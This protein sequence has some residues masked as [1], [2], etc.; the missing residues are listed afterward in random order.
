[1]KYIMLGTIS[2]QWASK[3]AERTARAKAKLQQLGIKLESA[4]Y[5][6]GEFD[7]VD[8]ADAP[9]P[10]AALAFSVWYAEKGYGRIQT[11]PAFDTETM[12]RA[13]KK[14]KS[15]GPAKSERAGKG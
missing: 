8:V 3:H 7:F 6:Q 12:E 10:E 2:E 11:L 13:A 14:A 9:E 15:G 1:M 5:T 4:Y